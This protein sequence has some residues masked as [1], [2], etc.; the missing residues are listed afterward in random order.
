MIWKKVNTL[1]NQWEHKVKPTKLP[2]A[3]ESASDQVVTGFSLASDWLTEWREFSGPFVERS[4]TKGKQTH[5]V[6]DT[7]KYMR[8]RQ[9]IMF[10]WI[11]GWMSI[12]TDYSN[13]T[14]LPLPYRFPISETRYNPCIRPIRQYFN[15]RNSFPRVIKLTKLPRE[16]IYGSERLQV[17]ISL[18]WTFY[19]F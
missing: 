12:L 2:K 13:L 3:R 7:N 17:R 14:C 15:F 1:R 9:E 18:R 5:I 16:I 8:K 19:Q 11:E 4:K 6:F 10:G